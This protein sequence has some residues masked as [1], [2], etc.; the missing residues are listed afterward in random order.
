MWCSV[1][2]KFEQ[3]VILIW[4]TGCKHFA[5]DTAHV[6]VDVDKEFRLPS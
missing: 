1:G 2:M 3:K 6:P 5:L 4:R